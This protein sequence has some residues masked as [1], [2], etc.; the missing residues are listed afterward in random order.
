MRSEEP[1]IYFL[2]FHKKKLEPFLLNFYNFI[3]KIGT[4]FA[5]LFLK[6]EKVDK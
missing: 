2:Q 4:F 5:P 3:R 6:V 1:K